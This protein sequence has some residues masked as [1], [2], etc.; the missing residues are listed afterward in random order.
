MKDGQ[1]LLFN[2]EKVNCMNR[3]SSFALL[4]EPLKLFFPPKVA[5]SIKPPT[6]FAYV[7]T[8][9]ACDYYGVRRCY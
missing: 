3:F 7:L 9:A 6:Q 2:D 4:S 8:R 1:W 5:N